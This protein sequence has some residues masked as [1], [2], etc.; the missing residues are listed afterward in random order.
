MKNIVKAQRTWYGGGGSG[1]GPTPP[2]GC[3]YELITV[4][5][6]QALAASSTMVQGTLYQVTDVTADW[7]VVILAESTSDVSF[8]GQGIYQN[9]LYTEAW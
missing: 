5:A 6:L 8:Q 3:C 1:S 9:N 2:S 4:A 7:Q